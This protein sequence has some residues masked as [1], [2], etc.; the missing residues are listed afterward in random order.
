NKKNEESF[1]K[2]GRNIALNCAAFQSS[3][4][5]GQPATPQN[6]VNGIKTKPLGF[7]TA[8]EENP[9]WMLDFGK[10]EAFDNILIYNRLDGSCAQRARTLRVLL[11]DDALNWTELYAHNGTSFGGVDGNPLHI[12]C[13]SSAARFVRIQLNERNYLHLVEVEIFARKET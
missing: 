10:V 5:E 4:F 7:H 13:E 11:S 6:A 3:S 2:F 8:L 9:W 1:S 12:Q